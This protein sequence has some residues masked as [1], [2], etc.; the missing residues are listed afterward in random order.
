VI[1]TEPAGI[2]AFVAETGWP[3]NSMTAE[4]LTY[5]GA[6]AGVSELQTFLDTYPCEPHSCRWP[7]KRRGDKRRS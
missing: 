5:E 3:T 4:N 1:I 2:D 7:G 6:T